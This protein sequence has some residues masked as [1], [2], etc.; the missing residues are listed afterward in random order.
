MNGNQ[1]M[2]PQNNRLT[3]IAYFIISLPR[4][5]KI[6]WLFPRQ[7]YNVIIEVCKKWLS[8]KSNDFIARRSIAIAYAYTQRYDEGFEYIKEIIEKTFTDSQIEKMLQFFVYPEFARKN[9]DKII[10]RCSF[11]RSRKMSKESRAKIDKVINDAH[12][13]CYFF[14]WGD[15]R[16]LNNDVGKNDK[17]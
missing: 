10:Y 6:A 14:P 16:Y 3:A 4:L 5:F 15:R 1:V 11:F 13:Y 7:E 9:Y 8:K 17:N 12:N 2:N